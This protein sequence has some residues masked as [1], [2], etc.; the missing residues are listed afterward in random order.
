MPPRTAG[1]SH[2]QLADH[3]YFVIPVF[4]EELNLPRVLHDLA[5]FQAD[6]LTRVGA[7]TFV[8]VDDGSS[9]RTAELLAASGQPNL[10]VLCHPENRGPGAAFQT[11]FR[12]LLDG[13]IGDDDLVI[14]LEGDATS[15]PRAFPRMLKRLDE[16]DDVVLA[17]P[18]L[19]GGGFTEVQGSRLVIS[20]VGNALTK[21][22]LNVRG[23][24][25]FSCFF[26]IYRGRALRAIDN[27]FPTIISSAGFECAAEILM[28]AV[29]LRLPVSE[30][31]F[32]VD[33][34]RRKGASKM[35]VMKTSLGYLHLFRRFGR[36]RPRP[37]ATLRPER[38]VSGRPTEQGARSA[39]SVGPPDGQ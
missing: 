21:L 29:R 8:F 34:A 19:Y 12:H 16:G 24:A 11:A 6:A 10:R 7:A 20:H 17:S 32:R 35:R 38:P 22:L 31:P 1:E 25:T 3:A 28:K 37:S 33:W 27:A 5:S 36:S 2:A 23:L 39:L 30:V 9:D 18:Y 14:T 4:N 13:G 26:R 15:D